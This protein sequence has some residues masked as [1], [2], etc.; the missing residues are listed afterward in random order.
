MTV[1]TV[2]PEVP[3]NQRATG[4]TRLRF[5]DLAQDGRLRL[6]GVWPPIGP[7]LWGRMDIAASLARLG[8]QGVRAVLTHVVLDGTDEPLSVRNRAETEVCYRLGHTVGE[9]GAVNRLI[10]DTWLQIAG[11]RGVP[12]APGMPSDGPKVVAARG[13][14]QHVL[15]KPAAKPG[16][17]RV[18]RLDDEA[19]PAV[20]ERRT[21]WIHPEPL[22]AL[23]AG[24]TPL[25]PAPV[26][27]ATPIVFGLCHTDGNQHVNFLAYP[28]MA[29]EAVLRRLHQLGKD[30]KLLARRAEIGYRKP[31]FAGQRVW[32][33][34][35]CFAHERGLGAV[36]GFFDQAPA[37][38]ALRPCCVA[39]LFFD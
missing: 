5:E 34:V 3:D 16:Q 8:E 32:L 18:L 22:L 10:F 2:A 21:Q 29:E 39:R 14:G 4:P 33:Q 13:Y 7:I 26:L 11:P 20:P 17:H 28:R 38:P 1:S 30:A 31:C 24:T 12:G 27:D 23:P 35:Q 36:V 6:E 9:D 19:L 37:E 25:D 15:T